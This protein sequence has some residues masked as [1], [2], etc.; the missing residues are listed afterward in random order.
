MVEATGINGTPEPSRGSAAPS[1]THRSKSA[2]T[3]GGSLPLGG[4]SKFSKRSAWTSRLASGSPGTIAAP[5]SPPLR[6]AS[7]LSSSSFPCSF[8]A[9]SEWHL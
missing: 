1:L 8:S 4:I 3:S 5:L 2:I 7:R 6:T 9:F